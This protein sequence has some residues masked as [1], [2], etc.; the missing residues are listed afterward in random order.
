MTEI[1]PIASPGFD[2]PWLTDPQHHAWLMQDARRQLRFFDASLRSDGGFD[3]LDVDGTP[4]PR[5]GQEL[6]TTA[7][8]I[9]SYMLGK[10][11]GHPGADRMIDAGMDYLWTRHRDAKWGGY[12]WGVDGETV[13]DGTKLAYG[14]VFVLLA[15]ASARLAGHPEADRL[16][17]DIAEVIER[18]FWAEETGLL[19]EEYTRDWYAFSF[20]RGMNSNMHGVEAMLAAHEATG[21]ALWLERAGRILDFFTARMAPDYDWRIP[22][23][24]SV[25]WEVDPTYSGNPMFRPAGTTPG[26]SLELARLLLQHWDLAGRPATGADTRARHLIERALGDAWLHGGGLAYTVDFDGSVLSRDRYWW[27]VSEGIGALASLIKLDGAEA[28]RESD[29]DWYRRLWR[30][31]ETAFVDTARGGWFPEVD[32]D[33]R[34]AARQF[35][36]K[37]DI[38]HALQADLYPLAPGLSRQA[39]ALMQGRAAAPFG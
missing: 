21:E 5:A 8:M 29:E 6:H 12:V 38:Y 11:I 27:P 10:A 32:A 1:A 37:P 18:H 24:Y 34:P 13:T 3:V 33:G 35:Q 26:H 25:Q 31:A 7:R 36:G 17:A 15:A 9:H 14:H 4:L 20:Y 30:Y 19:I 39:G 22:E 16:H 23:H 28:A 2:G